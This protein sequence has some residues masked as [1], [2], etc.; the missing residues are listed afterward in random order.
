MPEGQWSVRFSKV[1]LELSW[2]QLPDALALG[3]LDGGR[4]Q[5]ATDIK[6]SGT[7]LAQVD[8]GQARVSRMDSPSPERSRWAS[9]RPA[10]ARI[11]EIRGPETSGPSP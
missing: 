11:N 5:G 7:A 3:D 8:L 6:G 2:W 9:S 1:A 4:W 10:M